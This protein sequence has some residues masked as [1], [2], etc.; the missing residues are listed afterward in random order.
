MTTSTHE[1]RILDRPYL[2]TCSAEERPLLEQCVALVDAK[3]RQVREGSRVQGVDRIA[4]MAALVL[5]R[6]LLTATPSPSTTSP[7][8]DEKITRIREMV[9]EALMP[10]Q[11]LF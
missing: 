9:E 2:L 3:M 5:A 11:S 1:F 8:A 10:Q 4:V 6:D 7:E